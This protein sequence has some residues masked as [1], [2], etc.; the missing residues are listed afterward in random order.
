VIETLEQLVTGGRTAERTRLLNLRVTFLENYLEFLI[1]GNELGHHITEQ[2][3]K[4]AVDRAQAVHGMDGTQS[5][6]WEHVVQV[7]GGL[8]T[9]SSSENKQRTFKLL[10]RAVG[11]INY[12]IAVAVFE[13]PQADFSFQQWDHH[14]KKAI[15]ALEKL[16]ELG[17]GDTSNLLVLRKT[18]LEQYLSILMRGAVLG[19]DVTRQGHIE[20][21]TS[22]AQTLHDTDT[23]REQH[24][25]RVLLLI[26]G[27]K[28][29][30]QLQTKLSQ[31]LELVKQ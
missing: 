28:A 23:G 31:L 7:I 2:D 26:R 8:R 6:Q 19:Y 14:S 3:I 17:R 9:G 1:R 21:A 12:G 11:L 18:F 27:L 4:G 30:G 10:T 20:G 5:A 25:Q 13:G 16:V 15:D 22:R 29:D 24:W